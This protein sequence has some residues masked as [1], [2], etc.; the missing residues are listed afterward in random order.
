MSGEPED[1]SDAGTLMYNSLEPNLGLV[2]Q[3]AEPVGISA[4]RSL[5]VGERVWRV[6]FNARPGSV[7]EVDR[8]LPNMVLA[9]G[10]V[11]TPFDDVARRHDD[12]LAPAVRQSQRARC[13]AACAG[14]Q[15]PGWNPVHRRAKYPAR[16][17][18]DRRALWQV[19]G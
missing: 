2:S 16:Q 3:I 19:V 12:A 6:V 14:R 1:P 11:I 7:Y 17:P 13:R 5:V 15:S 4:D 10:T 8:V 18:A 9:S